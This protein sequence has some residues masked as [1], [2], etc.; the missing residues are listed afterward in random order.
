MKRVK[1]KPM[2]CREAGRR[3]AKIIDGLIAEA[4]R[5]EARQKR[6]ERAQRR[7]AKFKIV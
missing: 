6:A 5:D 2:T 3:H 4:R 7:R 1:K